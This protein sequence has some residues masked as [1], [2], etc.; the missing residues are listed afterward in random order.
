MATCEEIIAEAME[1]NGSLAL[2]ETP[3]PEEG[4]RGL[5]RLQSMFRQGAEAVFGRVVEYL[6]TDDYEAEEQQRVF[7]DGFTITLP[8]SIED[9]DSDTGYRRPRDL[10][11]IQVVDDGSDPEISIYDAHAGAWVR[12]DNLTMAGEC[13]LSARWRH[14]I[15]AALAQMMAP[16]SSAQGPTNITAAYAAALKSALGSRMSAPRTNA[17]VEYM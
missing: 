16:L 13:P 6:A 14:G 15:V 1:E 3:P 7:A 5:T 12:I 4:V 9:A 11:M 10:A 17:D 8:T 2:G